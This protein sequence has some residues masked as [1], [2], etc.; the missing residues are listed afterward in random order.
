MGD[1]YGKKL[2]FVLGW[3]WLSLFNLA[4]GFAPNEIVYDVFRALA[5]I[6][7]SALMP[8]AS[9]LFGTAYQ[10]G[11]RKN[12]VFAVFGAVAPRTILCG[13]ELMNAAGFVIGAVWGG[14]FGQFDVQWRWIY[15][16][17]AIVS[18]IYAL[19]TVIVVPNELNLPTGGSFDY[20]GSFLGVSGLIPIFFSLK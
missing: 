12:M 9:A 6:G 2:I 1:I 11:P 13:E 14:L 16:S 7:P 17:M 18:M 8:N 4:T 20:I 19:S 3:V 15:W 5:G 10:P